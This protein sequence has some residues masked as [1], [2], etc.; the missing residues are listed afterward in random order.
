MSVPPIRSWEDAEAFA[1][2]LPGTEPGTSYRMP[3][4][5]VAA[6]GR[7]FLWTSHEAET[8]FAVPIEAGTAE[9]LMETDPDSFWQ[10]PHYAGGAAILIRY[11][12]EDPERVRYVI[13]QAYE[14]AAAKKPVRPRKR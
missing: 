13:E 5:K 10:S 12:S 3:T 2:S 4:V 6:N 7:A 14:E 9:M 1:L 8:S 11:S